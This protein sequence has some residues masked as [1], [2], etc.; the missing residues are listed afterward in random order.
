MPKTDI[1]EIQRKT[2]AHPD[3]QAAMADVTTPKLERISITV[4]ASYARKIKAAAKLRGLTI[5]QFVIEALDQQYPD[6]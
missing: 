2:Q 1:A 5:K 6:V 3:K 4:D